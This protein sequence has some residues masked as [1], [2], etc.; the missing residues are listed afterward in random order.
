MNVEWTPAALDDLA[1]F[2]VALSLAEQDD[3]SRTVLR[4]NAELSLYPETLGESREENCRVWCVGRLA[5]RYLML[6][7]VGIVTVYNA[8]LLRGSHR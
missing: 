4:V 8:T 1:N 6:P 5:V 3:I 2:Y 7:A